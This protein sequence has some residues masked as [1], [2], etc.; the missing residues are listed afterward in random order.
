LLKREVSPEGVTYLQKL[1]RERIPFGTKDFDLAALRAGMGSRREPTIKG[2]KLIKVKVGDVPCEWV[3]APG[4]DP[5]LRLLY[6][7]GGGFVSGSGGYYLRMAAQISAAAKCAVLLPDYRL[8]PEHPFPAGLDDCV[9][10]HDWILANGPVGQSP[11]RATFVAGDSAGGS[12]TLTT[13]LALRDRKLTLPAAGIAISPCTDFTLASE[14]LQS[15]HDPII[16][17]K[18]MPVFR[19]HYLGKTDPRDPLVSPV[20]GNYRGLPPLLI[21]I[22][23]HEMLRDDGIRAA[24]KARADGISVKL[25]VWPGMFHVFQS[26]ELPEARDAITHLADFI[27]RTVPADGKSETELAK[28]AANMKPGTWAELK[29]DNYTAELLRVQNGNILGYT[30]TAVWDPKSQQ[31]L[32]VGQGHYAAVKFITYSAAANAWKLMPTP[33]WWD[34]DPK[35]GKGPI[36]HAYQNNTIDVAHG[37]FFHHQSA[38]RLV[39][40]YDIAGDKWSTLPEIKGA[41]TGHGTALAYFPERKGLVRV[42]GGAVHFFDEEK[43]TWSLLKERFPMGPYHNIA[44]YNRAGKSVIFGA[45]N[46]SKILHRMDEK[47]NVTPLKEA[48]FVIRISS[49]V[50]AVD[51]VSGDLLVISSEDKGKFHALDVKRNE[52]RQLPDAPISE[53]A[54]ASI[55]AHGVTLYFSNRPTKVY[56]YKHAKSVTN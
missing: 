22:G 17:A 48:P 29:T 51:P 34:G 35:T 13:V 31:V 14:S 32:F 15:V 53:G 8:A 12:L 54:S 47:G 45:G 3:V 16:S 20:F 30:D 52:W 10:A 43:N 24:K 1:R 46:G 41:A 28:L 42:Y 5:D 55:D 19:D 7:H 49:T 40:R 2:V 18:T 6:I 9:R 39:H 37:L 23:E 36:G 27:S 25:E 4:A 56:L 11:A 33:V 44:K 38:T 26:H 21:Q 50:T